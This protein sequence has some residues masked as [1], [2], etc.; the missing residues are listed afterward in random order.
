MPNPTSR[1]T[2]SAPTVESDALL[3]VKELA[4]RYGPR[5]VLRGISLDVAPGEF[6]TVLG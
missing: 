5:P 1:D 2:A 4:K 3:R 6:L